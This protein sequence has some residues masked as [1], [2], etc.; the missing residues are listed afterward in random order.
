MP[1]LE[2]E[3][4]ADPRE[5]LRLSAGQAEPD[6]P[7]GSGGPGPRPLGLSE[8][9]VPESLQRRAAFA[10]ARTLLPAIGAAVA[11]LFVAGPGQAL[12]LGVVVGLVAAPLRRFP[13]PLHLMPT[14]RIVLALVPP[15]L[16]CGIF[17]LADV[18]GPQT[19]SLSSGDALAAGLVSAEVA[20]LIELFYPRWLCR[21]PLRIATLGASDFAIALERE[22]NETG[23]EEAKLVGW[24]DESGAE[25]L[26]EVVL[27]HGID[28]VVRVSG[29]RGRRSTRLPNEDGF[30][31]LLDLPVRTIGADQLY[32]NLFGHV[33]MGAIDSRWYLFLMHPEF[34]TTRP[35]TDRISELATAIPLLVLSSPFLLLA[36]VAIK[37]TD[38]GPV[39]Y[40]QIRVGAA[41]REFRILKLRTM[42]VSSERDGA[43]WSSAD[44]A[45]VTAVGRV[46]RRLHLDELP[47]LI[48]VLRGEMTI[49]GPRP[50]RPEMVAELERTFPHYRRR[51]LIKPGVTGWAQVRCGYAGSTLGTAWKLCHDLYYLKHRSRLVNAMI[52]LETLTI[53]GLDSHRPLR[54]PASQFLFGQDLGIDLAEDAVGPLPPELEGRVPEPVAAAVPPT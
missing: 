9:R 29:P 4:E 6:A 46:L 14:T 7:R 33:P 38:R 43:R 48:N 39:I 41:G 15:L 54:A 21:R 25:A 45:R 35:I 42:S 47:Q 36:A 37:L 30:E 31:V 53:A 27:A 20:L 34:N 32:E 3:H 2:H 26:R 16:G 28:L 1:T 8:L 24:I 12:L 23:M 17:A 5:R 13:M 52:V 19:F 18:F 11:A 22:L 44:D 51:H 40:R 50:E 10:R 49:V